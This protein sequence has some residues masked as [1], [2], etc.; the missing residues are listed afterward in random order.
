V[1][2]KQRVVAILPARIESSRLP[3][4]VLLDICGLPMIVHVFKRCL[5][6]KKLDEVYVATDSNEIKE[7]VE[8]HGGKVIMTSHNHQTGTDRIAEAAK[9]IDAEI[10]VNVQGDEAL[11]NPNHIDKV[12]D[13]LLENPDINVGILVSPYFKKNSPSDIKVVLNNNNDIL[14][15]SRSDIPSDS[16]TKNPSMLKAYH[17]VPF[18]KPFLLKFTKWEKGILEKIEF[19]EYLRILEYGERFRAIRVDSDAISVDTIDDLEYVRE[20]MQSD[21]W[22][23]QYK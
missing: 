2:Y 4:K 10:V 5:L 19:N 20:Q 18:R 6:A 8:N 23:P 14:Y 21:L 15:S 16:R 12:V 7:V 9:N 3:R 11:V 22:F 13:E 17:I 1:S